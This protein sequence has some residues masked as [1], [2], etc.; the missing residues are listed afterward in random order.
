MSISLIYF[1]YLDN[2]EFLQWFKRFFEVHYNVDSNYNARER[3]REALQVFNSAR[4]IRNRQSSASSTS[5]AVSATPCVTKTRTSSR[6][7]RCSVATVSRNT[8]TNAINIEQKEN[9]RLKRE[10]V[11]IKNTATELEKERDYYFDKLHQMDQLFHSDIDSAE[12][13][14]NRIQSILYDNV[15]PRNEEPSSPGPIPLP[16]KI[17]PIIHDKENIG[18][19]STSP[20]F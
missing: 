10:I 6:K 5:S 18:D 2:L 7:S 19:V 12:E 4:H 15:E 1:Y 11:R 3:R 8:N 13:F 20:L 16:E 14:I 9:Q 17:S